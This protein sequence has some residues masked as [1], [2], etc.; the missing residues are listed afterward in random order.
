MRALSYLPLNLRPYWRCYYGHTDAV[1]YVIDSSD[2]DRLGI[3][4]SEFIAMMEVSR[5]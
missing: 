2:R 4:A 1:I 3:S 5:Y